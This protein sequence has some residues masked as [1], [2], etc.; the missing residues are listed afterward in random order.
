M[1]KLFLVFVVFAT[2]YQC[3]AQIMTAEEFE[4]INVDE[5]DG[6]P[7]NKPHYV[8]ASRFFMNNVFPK[9]DLGNI[10]KTTVYEYDAI[11]K[12]VLFDRLNNW[13]IKNFSDGK[14]VILNP[15]KNLGLV[16]FKCP[17]R[18]IVPEDNLYAGADA[19][20]WVQIK[21]DIKENK[22]RVTTTLLEYKVEAS[23][24]VRVAVVKVK[25]DN[26]SMYTWIPTDSFPFKSKENAENRLAAKMFVASCIFMQRISATIDDVAKGN[27]SVEDDW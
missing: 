16:S 26:A 10:Y 24:D 22:I 4:T 17:I 23:R 20:A 6:K 14:T 11:E 18:V 3:H 27:K 7:D 9:T 5:Y 12:D 21:I 8:S 15:D 25:N 2:Y 13:T 19:N 1:K